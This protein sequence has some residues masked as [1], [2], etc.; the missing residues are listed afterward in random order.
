MFALFGNFASS[1][2][3]TQGG[4]TWLIR[5]LAIQSVRTMPSRPVPL[6]LREVRLDLRE[7]LVVVVDVF[8]VVDLDARSAPGSRFI[9]WSVM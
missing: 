3:C 4:S 1:K 9:D 5:R 6:P 2:G 8:G 7:V